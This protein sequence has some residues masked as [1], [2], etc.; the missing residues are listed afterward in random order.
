MSE[1]QSDGCTL[2]QHLES[3]ERIT[4]K[5]S[6]QLEN[7]PK[8]PRFYEYI[9]GWFC[10]LNRSR[11]NNGFGLNALSYSEIQ[12]WSNLLSI[13]PH[14]WE[15]ELLRS[16]DNEYLKVANKPKNKGKK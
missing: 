8:M 12:A 15:I 7:A 4:G 2:R 16:I 11:G 10:D 3:F 6:P 13:R 5:K 14:A 9:W 1:A